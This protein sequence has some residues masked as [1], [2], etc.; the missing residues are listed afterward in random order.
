M[1]RRNEQLQ[2]AKDFMDAGNYAEASKRLSPL[3]SARVPE[4]IFLASTFSSSAD[5][6]DA[7][8]ELRSFHMLQESAD[9]GYVPAM[10][11]LASCYDAGDLTAQDP[12]MAAEW[13]K[14]AADGGDLRAKFRYGLA[15]SRGVGVQRDRE[16][17]EKLIREAAES[18]VE[19]AMD[20]LPH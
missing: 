2:M 17:G 7:Q 15:L 16:L 6:T 18:G 9:L 12:A 8:F 3:V 13:Y 4:A 5:E 19:D 14:R 10:Y 11:A 20:N 1:D